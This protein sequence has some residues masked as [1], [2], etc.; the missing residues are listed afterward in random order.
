MVRPPIHTYIDSPTTPSVDYTLELG[1][2]RLAPI[3]G[4]NAN[5][6]QSNHNT[7]TGSN[8]NMGYSINVMVR[9]LEHAYS[10][11]SKSKKTLHAIVKLSYFRKLVHACSPNQLHTPVHCHQ[12]ISP[13]VHQTS[14]GQNLSLQTHEPVHLPTCI[15]L[16]CWSGTK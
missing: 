16:R 10:L 13:E 7:I 4:S 3:T 9:K 12:R 14:L 5:T 1:S 11:K 6:S 15:P 2:L 8:Y